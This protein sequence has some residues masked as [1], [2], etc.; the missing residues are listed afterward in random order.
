MKNYV[1]KIKLR[2]N[3]ITEL[4]RDLKKCHFCII[5]KHFPAMYTSYLQTELF[6]KIF[7]PS[8]ISASNIK[9][10]FK[11]ISFTS[12][13]NKKTMYVI[14]FF[15]I[16]SSNSRNVNTK[17]LIQRGNFTPFRRH[18]F[19]PASQHANPAIKSHEKEK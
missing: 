18:K 17:T 13:R 1:V 5:N 4:V 14:E 2:Q 19:T 8:L 10:S 15:N 7:H 11:T 12:A 3:V 9:F 16:Q 6:T